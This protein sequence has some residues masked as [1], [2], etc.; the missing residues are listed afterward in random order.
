MDSKDGRP[1]LRSRDKALA[2]VLEDGFGVRWK[3]KIVCKI[4]TLNLE[5][6]Q[7]YSKLHCVVT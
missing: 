1:P 5:G 7:K 4:S 2:G 3:L 6:M